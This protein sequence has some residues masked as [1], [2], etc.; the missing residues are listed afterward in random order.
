MYN[1][2]RINR[3]CHCCEGLQS[4]GRLGEA[5]PV[6]AEVENGVVR[7]HENIPKDP[8]WTTRRRYVECHEPTDTHGLTCLLQL[9]NVLLWC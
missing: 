7:A 1:T 9:H 8:E 4:S 5:D 6:L 2:G 3:R